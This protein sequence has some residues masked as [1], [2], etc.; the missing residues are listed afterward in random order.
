MLH[1]FFIY[2]FILYIF[3]GEFLQKYKYIIAV[4]SLILLLLTII[5]PFNAPGYELILITLTLGGGVFALIKA[6]RS[7]VL[8]EHRIMRLYIAS[9]VIFLIV[10]TLSKLIFRNEWYMT[11]LV[12]NMFLIMAQSLVLSSRYTNAFK[13]AEEANEQRRRFSAETDFYKKMSHQLLTPL[14]IVS[15]NIQV[16]QSRSHE[17][18]V[19]LTESQDEIMK[20]SDMINTALSEN[21]EKESGV[22]D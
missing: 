6:A 16:A 11:G 18:D 20:M 8:K 3:N 2:L 10:G 5:L 7:P 21:S 22:H 12:N 17:A 19:L 13:I 9:F 1:T 4:P 15:T 14:T